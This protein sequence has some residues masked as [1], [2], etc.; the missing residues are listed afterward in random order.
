[1]KRINIEDI[2]FGLTY[3]GY[4]WYSDKKKPEQ[5]TSISKEDFKNLPFIVEGN[6]YSEQE[7]ISI[8]IKHRDGAYFIYRADLKNLKGDQKTEQ[9]YIAH[10]LDGVKKIKM[11]QYWEESPEDE[12][13]AGMKTLVPSWQAFVGFDNTKRT[14]K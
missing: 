2:N 9:A 3:E 10:D 1:M 14:E 5:R 7:Q 11:L 12:L 4:L 8:S 13:L 6:F